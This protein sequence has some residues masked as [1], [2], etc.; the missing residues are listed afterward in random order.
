[1]ADVPITGDL[2]VMQRQILVP[3]LSH[4]TIPQEVLAR[5]FNVPEVSLSS[6]R[7]IQQGGT[8]EEV[9]RVTGSVTWVKPAEGF[10]IQ[11]GD[12]S[13]WIQCT[14]PVLPEIGKT[15]MCSGLPSSFHG[16]GILMNAIWTDAPDLVA[17]VLASTLTDG[18]FQNPYRHGCLSAVQGVLIEQV[19]GPAEI[20]LILQVGESVVFSHIRATSAFP[21]LARGSLINVTG[22]FLNRPTPMLDLGESLGAHHLLLRNPADVALV[23]EPSFWTP[24]RVFVTLCAVLVATF[25]AAA[26]GV[27]LRRK[28]KQQADVI[29]DSVG[30]QVVEEERVR[31]A[32]EW[33]DMFEQHFAGLTMLLDATSTMVPSGS[34]AAGMLDRAAR[35][36]DHSRSQARHAIWDLRSPGMGC[37]IPFADHLEKALEIS[38]PDDPEERLRIRCEDRVARFPGRVTQRL[39]RIANEGVTNAFKHADARRIEVSWS[40]GG[41]EWILS[42][43]DDG[44]GIPAKSIRTRFPQRTLRIAGNARARVAAARHVG[45]SVPTRPRHRR[46]HRPSHFPETDIRTVNPIRIL[47]VDDHYVVRLGLAESINIEPNLE[48]VAEAE[49]GAEAIDLYHKH[50]PNLV[51]MD[52]RLPDATGGEIIKL[53]IEAAPKARV[54]VL[55]AFD[56]EE[57]I[58]Q[59]VHAG[60]LG[61]LPKSSRRPEL[62]K[63]INLAAHG[64]LAL[65]PAIATKL[66][67]R[68]RR[69]DLTPRELEVVGQLVKGNS[70]KEIAFLLDISDN[71]VKL[72]LTRIMQKLRAKDRTHVASIALQLGL[73]D[74]QSPGHVV[75]QS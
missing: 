33:H 17:D 54:L 24:R 57:T 1:M 51:I 55:S 40:D 46:D 31:I 32:R 34:P 47:L 2:L 4:V 56:T 63:A 23:A 74:P 41:D 52:W 14:Q 53:L 43:Q 29:R 58:F 38:W 44:R 65:P 35:M 13:A 16:A 10:V 72:H 64:E 69:P 3:G 22:V 66:S 42:I 5:Q 12:L 49:C 36:A 25:L 8:D 9:N 59:A 70:N 7:W 39:I 61:Y 67:S 48:V 6:L 20:L 37:D 45:N 11:K 60:A 30:R 27:V 68:M 75:T 28:V 71:T 73:V 50:Q 62:I 21:E 19:N 26:W 15:V 18:D